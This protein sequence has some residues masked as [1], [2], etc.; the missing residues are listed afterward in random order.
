M[1]KRD[2]QENKY[3]KIALQTEKYIRSLQY[4]TKHGVKWS[5]EESFHGDPADYYDDSCFYAGSAGI[6]H[7]YIQ[8]ADVFENELFLKTAELGADE[9]INQ[10]ENKKELDK[11]FSKWAFSTGYIGIA[12]VL[13]ELYEFND[14]E[15]YKTAVIDIVEECIKESQAGE[16]GYFWSGSIGVVADSGTLLFL[17]KAAKT[18]NKPTWKE[19]AIEAGYYLL[20][21]AKTREEGSYYIGLN[22]RAHTILPGF[23]MGS[24]GIGFVLLRLY[25]ESNDDVF[26]NETRGIKEFYNNIA[27]SCDCGV[28]TPHDIPN[29]NL[30]YLNY[31]HGAV[32]TARYFYYY[33]KLLN[34]PEYK[35][36][37]LELVDGI[38]GSGA[39]EIHSDGYWNIFN[40]CCGTAGMLNLFLSTWMDTEDD[41]HLSYAKRAA[42]Y[43]VGHAYHFKKNDEVQTKWIQAYDRVQPDKINSAI[44]YYDGAAGIA[45]TL[46]HFGLALENQLK[47]TR[48]IDD[49]F[50]TNFIAKEKIPYAKN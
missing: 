44:G 29:N 5:L 6:V 37:Y 21:K 31:C 25:E 43:L 33:D 18:L 27:V 50:P 12:Y 45:S 2:G 32:G 17:L 40:F 8:L 30:Y 47:V 49:P 3:F 28:V 15:K 48:S 41:I 39:P 24:A 22:E 7:F 10:W 11:N 36:F 38:I 20:D 35:N 46:I 4:E 34:E 42:D 9:L 26:L 14:Q 23:P 1:T 16:R 19:F 13:L